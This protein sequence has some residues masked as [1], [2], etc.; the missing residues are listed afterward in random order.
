MLLR[1]GLE[2][3]Q[4]PD[5]LHEIAG[6]ARPPLGHRAT[7]EHADAARAVDGR[8]LSNA[9]ASAIGT[10]VLHMMSEGAVMHDMIQLD[11]AVVGRAQPP[12]LLVFWKIRV[13]RRD[14]VIV[15]RE[16][17]ERCRRAVEEVVQMRRR[18]ACVFGNRHVA[19]RRL[20]PREQP[21]GDGRVAT[22]LPHTRKARE[23]VFAR[24]MSVCDLLLRLAPAAVLRA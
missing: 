1:E 10:R 23:I 12:S 3:R 15:N 4:E 19:E 11:R 6:I 24:W 8:Y 5:L 18:V 7:R 13:N 9:R 17:I 16:S 14:D 2:R 22:G 20:R 21:M